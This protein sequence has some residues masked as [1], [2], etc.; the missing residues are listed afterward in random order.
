MAWFVTPVTIYIEAEAKTKEE[1][2]AQTRVLLDKR[3]ICQTFGY[4]VLDRA[5]VRA[6]YVLEETEQEEE[7]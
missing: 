4:N 1:A 7:D 3:V 5:G 6:D 2:I